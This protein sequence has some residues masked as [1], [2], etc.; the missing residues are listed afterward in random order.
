MAPAR[1]SVP[2][3]AMLKFWNSPYTG[4]LG[5]LGNSTLAL[6]DGYSSNYGRLV[7]GI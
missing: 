5:T 7:I 1:C 3:K 6:G 4:Q 2:T